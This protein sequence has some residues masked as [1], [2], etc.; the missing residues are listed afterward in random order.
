VFNGLRLLKLKTDMWTSDSARQWTRHWLY[1]WGCANL[2]LFLAIQRALPDGWIWLPEGMSGLGS[3]WGAP[4]MGLPQGTRLAACRSQPVKAILP[5]TL[6][7]ADFVDRTHRRLAFVVRFG[8]LASAVLIAGNAPSHKL[9]GV[10][11]STTY[12]LQ[13]VVPQT[14]RSR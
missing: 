10:V 5:T 14:E 3:H 11:S 4:V 8:M 13:P 7:T 12:D 2:D 1:H 9:F 6:R